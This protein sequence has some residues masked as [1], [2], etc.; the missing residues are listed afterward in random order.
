MFAFAIYERPRDYPAGYVVRR[1]DYSAGQLDPAW[2]AQYTPTLLEARLVVP[3]GL[4]RI[5]RS[6][7]DDP[8]IR[9]VW[10]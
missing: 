9:E 3:L 7:S 8:C 1:W 5:P 2:V 10:L 6:P 4:A